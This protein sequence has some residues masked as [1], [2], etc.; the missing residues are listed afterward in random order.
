MQLNQNEHLDNK[1]NGTE[2][3]YEGSLSSRCPIGKQYPKNEQ[4][5][6]LAIKTSISLADFTLCF[7]AF[8]VN[9]EQ[10]NAGWG[11]VWLSPCYC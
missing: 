8:I 6:K 10:V 3:L 11:Q 4:F 9:F 2:T 7:G 1:V 5:S